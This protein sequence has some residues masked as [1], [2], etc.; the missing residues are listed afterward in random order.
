MTKFQWSL[1][2]G[3]YSDPERLWPYVCRSQR[4]WSLEIGHSIQIG[5]DRFVTILG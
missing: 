3:T 4:H 5:R 2:N 1:T